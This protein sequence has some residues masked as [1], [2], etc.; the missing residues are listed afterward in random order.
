MAIHVG[1]TRWSLLKKPALMIGWLAAANLSATGQEPESPIQAESRCSVDLRVSGAMKDIVSNALLRGVKRPEADVRA[2]LKNAESTYATGEDLLRAAARRFEIDEATMAAEVERFRHCNCTHGSGADSRPMVPGDGRVKDR[3]GDGVAV[4]VTSFA[5]DVTLHVVLHELGHAL[6]R[7]FDLPILGNEE[8]M[9]DAFA[10]HYLTTHLPD[11]A[12]DVLKAR[13]TSLMIEAREVSR[14]EWTVAGEHDNDA[15]RAFQIAA[16]AVAADPVKYASVA[17]V[18]EMSDRD[19]QKAKDY[20]AEIHRSWRRILGPL[21]MAD[22]ARS[23]EAHVVC[24]FESG[25]SD[26]SHAISLGAELESIVTRFDWHS[27]VTVRFIAGEGRAGWSRSA[28]T[29]TVPS[30]Y[31]RRFVAQGKVAKF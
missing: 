31:I 6:I 11:R 30:E 27:Q 25:L 19:V 17:K 14:A 26:T 15:R 12:A 8:T 7:E 13:T 20:G 9:A 29:I 10:T 28:R 4:E 24:N 5:K 23:K 18:V 16:L 1:S 21:R 22:G 3:A 2:F